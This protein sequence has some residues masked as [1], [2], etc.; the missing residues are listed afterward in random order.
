MVVR[1]GTLLGKQCL[2]IGLRPD[3]IA[4]EHNPAPILPKLLSLFGVLFAACGKDD[5]EMRDFTLFLYSAFKSRILHNLNP[6]PLEF[7]IY[8]I[9][10]GEQLE[11][12]GCTSLP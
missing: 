12:L 8:P 5:A 6:M 11:L 7:S 10:F 2:L 9:P 1:A 3:M 4:L